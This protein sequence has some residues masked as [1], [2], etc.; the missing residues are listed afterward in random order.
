VTFLELCQAVARDVGVAASAAADAPTTV[1]GQTGELRRI[2]GYVQDAYLATQGKKYDF[3]LEEVTMTVPI[4]GNV[5]TA[6]VAPNRYLKESAYHVQAGSNAKSWLDYLDWEEF[7]YEYDDAWLAN[8]AVP[9]CWT[10]RRS[11]YAFIVNARPVT[12]TVPILVERY[13]KPVALAADGDVPLLPS[14]LHQLIVELA[15][16]RYANYDEAGAMRQTTQAEV[17]RLQ[18]LL[19]DR[20]L[21][22]MGLGATLLDD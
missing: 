1:V 20:C 22:E 16:L 3:M 21:P 12:A 18:M 4:A 13:K 10:I 5:V 7:R 14:D 6:N 8:N 15:K 9:S 19:D 17:T 2:V 11:D